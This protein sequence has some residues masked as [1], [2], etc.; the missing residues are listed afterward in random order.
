M[1]DVAALAGVGRG[2]VSR[3]VN[4]SDNVSAHT[5]QSVLAAIRR[6]GYLVNAHAR[7]LVTHRSGSVAFALSASQ[8][9][10]FDDPQFHTLLRGCM[11]ELSR[12]GFTMVLTMADSTNTGPDVV[13]LTRT[14]HVD[15]ALA[16]SA[17]STQAMMSQLVSEGVPVVACG[18]PVCTGR[19][20]VFVA[21]DDRYAAAEMVRYLRNGGRRRVGIITAPLDTPAGVYRLAGYHDVV[22]HEDDTRLVVA[23]G[24]TPASGH[25][26]M[27]QLLAQAPDLDAVFVASGTSAL[28][29]LEAL[30]RAGKQIPRDL[31][32]GC[33][34]DSEAVATLRPAL[35]T[36]RPPVEQV[37]VEMVRLLMQLL[38]GR[39]PTPV[40]V[41][42]K[43]VIRDSA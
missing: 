8:E 23:G 39:A 35:T 25:D 41:P 5:R 9:P 20:P 37:G 12:H 29:A 11:R 36:I 6:T 13:T 19:D 21:T 34:D 2:T 16:M 10:L 3:V 43:L 42:S 4:G 14:G 38:A 30:H 22:G 1:D 18:R 33:F 15:G 27:C 31:T 17:H 28:G 7:G 24:Y 32:V 40:L 26:A